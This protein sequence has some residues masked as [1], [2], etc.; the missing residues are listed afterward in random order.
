M[1]VMLSA[2]T[3][4]QNVQDTHVS[5]VIS[6]IAITGRDVAVRGSVSQE[7][8]PSSD[9]HLRS[10]GVVRETHALFLTLFKTI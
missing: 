6:V 4:C 5:C 1:F 2:Q 10:T 3:E 9:C 7:C 8:L